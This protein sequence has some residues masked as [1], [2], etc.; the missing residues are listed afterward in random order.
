M[1]IKA[2]VFKR[3]SGKSA[4]KWIV[5]VTY[6]DE[7]AGSEVTREKTCARRSDAIDERD[8]LVAET[9]KSHGQTRHGDRMTF[10]DL[11]DRCEAAFYKPAVIV[12]GHKIAGV[13]SIESVRAL[14]K[15][16]R[17]YF[18]RM[19]IKS[20][21]TESLLSYKIH[22]TNPKRQSTRAVKIATVNRELS[23]MRKMLRHAMA[24]GWVLKDIFLD[25]KVI[26]TS[27]ETARSRLLSKEE[28]V[29]LL[30]ACGGDRSITY[31]RTVG[32]VRRDITANI[33][34]DNPHLR[35]IILMALHCGLRRGE[36]FKLRWEDIDLDNNVLHVLG[37]HTKTE[38]PR[39]APLS[40]EVR[41]QI[42][43]L[44]K[45]GMDRP[46]PFTDIKRSFA[47]AKRLAGLEDLRF[48]DLRRTAITRWL[49]DGLPL[50]F[51]A[52]FAGH[53]QLQTTLK[54]YAATDI[55]AAQSL[56][57]RI[58]ARRTVPSP[59]NLDLEQDQNVIN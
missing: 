20:L 19:P 46:F 43:E 45:L 39:I 24:Q 31:E 49:E 51:A 2:K 36:I 38:K 28:E 4:G 52:K 56:N 42:L 10:N 25:A 3:K 27:M 26:E 58:N 14:I 34:A 41:E 16:L 22:R 18:G 33:S 44:R 32:G 23:V 54:H 7:I 57:E 8:R 47:T 29:R 13:K 21:R 50:A 37:T 35:A 53:S 6:L 40:D 15:N 48:H 1:D 59:L 17:S 9:S 12:E 55:D 5:R 30:A 11:A